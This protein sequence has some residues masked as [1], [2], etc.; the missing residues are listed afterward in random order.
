MPHA[1]VA[2]KQTRQTLAS[3]T[4]ASG[5]DDDELMSEF[6]LEFNDDDSEDSGS[7]FEASDSDEAVEDSDEEVKLVQ[8]LKGMDA[9]EAEGVLMS[10][11][12]QMSIETSQSEQMKGASSFGAGPSTPSMRATGAALRAAAA[13]DRLANGNANIFDGDLSESDSV[14]SEVSEPLAKGKGKA[15][16]MASKKTAK[17]RLPSRGM[18]MAQLRAEKRRARKGVES[19]RLNK[20]AELELRQK[21]GRK[22]THVRL[23]PL[24]KC[25]QVRLT[26]LAT[27]GRLREPRLRYSSITQVDASTST[28]D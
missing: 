11:A 22:L 18:T 14:M 17:A 16:A 19:K 13:E 5:D 23:P 27:I 24:V 1:K 10:A 26:D 25:N 15:K 21:L 4:P 7:E 12:I 9:D 20:M 6:E 28:E 8:D 3:V 2:N